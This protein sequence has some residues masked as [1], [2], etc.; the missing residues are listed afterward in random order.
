MVARRLHV[1]VKTRLESHKAFKHSRYMRLTRLV[2]LARVGASI[3]Q[4]RPD[5][6][7]TMSAGR[8]P[9]WDHLW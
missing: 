8:H 7:R 4:G 2:N 9:P 3:Q 5:V 1:P 6:A